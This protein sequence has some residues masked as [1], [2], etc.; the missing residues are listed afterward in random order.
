MIT[1]GLYDNDEYGGVE[2]FLNKVLEAHPDAYDLPSSNGDTQH[3][4]KWMESLNNLYKSNE[5]PSAQKAFKVYRDKILDKDTDLSSYNAFEQFNSDREKKE[6]DEWK[7]AS[8]KEREALRKERDEFADYLYEKFH[9]E[10]RG[11]SKKTGKPFSRDDYYRYAEQTPMQWSFLSDISDGD[12]S[13]SLDRAYRMHKEWRNY[14]D[15]LDR[16]RG[17]KYPELRYNN[18]ELLEDYMYDDY[19]K[20]ID[21]DEAFTNNLQW[22]KDRYEL[23]WYMEDRLRDILERNRRD[24]TTKNIIKALRPDDES[25]VF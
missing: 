7:E 16:K 8:N 11:I 5:S 12:W 25:G 18:G 24:L 6:F 17:I 10:P 20:P 23:P 19:G 15:E 3:T 21:K 4:P 22:F 2:G 13:P 9:N 14:K 1:W